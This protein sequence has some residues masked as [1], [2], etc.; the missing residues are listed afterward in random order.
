MLLHLAERAGRD[1]FCRFGLQH[2]PLVCHFTR[3]LELLLLSAP[4]SRDKL[5][6]AKVLVDEYGEGSRGL[7]HA[8]LYRDFL[9]HAGVGEGE[10]LSVRLHTVV[11]DFITEHLRICQEEPFLVG[12]GAVGPGHE[13]TIPHMF[14]PILAG[15]RRLGFAETE[16]EY[17]SLHMKQDVDHGK[18]LEEALLR[19][20]HSVEAQVQIRRGA[21]LSLTARKRFWDGVQTRIHPTVLLPT[22]TPEDSSELNLRQF[23]EQVKVLV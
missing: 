10:Q 7:D 12:L 14:R 6:I 22:G 18:W 19:H 13:W 9:R 20:A 3:Y 1:E 21:L 4:D 2:Y 5:W 11:T 15:L 23:R 8:T 16:I 17:F